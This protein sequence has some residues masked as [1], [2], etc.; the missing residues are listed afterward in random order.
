[1]KIKAK[2]I[3]IGILLFIAA[4]GLA[5][6][7][8]ATL[9]FTIENATQNILTI[10]SQG[11]LNIS[12]NIKTNKSLYVDGNIYAGTDKLKEAIIDFDTTC[13]ATDKLYISGNDLACI[14]DA[15]ATLTDTNASTACAADQ[16]LD[17][18]NNCVAFSYTNTTYNATYDAM[19]SGGD[20]TAPGA[21]VNVTGD[22]MTGELK[23]VEANI[24]IS[25][26]SSYGIAANH[27]NA[28]LYFDSSG[29]VV[30]HLEA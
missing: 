28:Y 30:I 24:T 18:D 15:N 4:T 29:G 10:D 14:A 17:G 1:M 21:Y 27:T 2:W 12:G 3:V 23:M 11:H 5:T 9:R 25:N 19:A 13:A 16:F 8:P 20:S 26:S 6:G 22:T 7:I